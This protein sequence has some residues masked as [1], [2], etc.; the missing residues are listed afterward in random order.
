M[1]IIV[2]NLSN[3]F[4]NHPL[5]HILTKVSSGKKSTH[6]HKEVYVWLYVYVYN[7]LAVT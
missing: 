5:H 7:L 3:R 4:S 2:V 1:A 6:T